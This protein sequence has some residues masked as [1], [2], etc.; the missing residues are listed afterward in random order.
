M[1][2]F[3]AETAAFSDFLRE[4]GAL[5]D[6]LAKTLFAL[7]SGSDRIMKACLVKFMAACPGDRE[8]FRDARGGLRW[9]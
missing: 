5:G 8:G 4:P 2:H 6:G 1:G 9:L 7:D 3:G